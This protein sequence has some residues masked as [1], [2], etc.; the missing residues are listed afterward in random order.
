MRRLL[1]SGSVLALAVLVTVSDGAERRLFRP[2]GSLQG[3]PTPLESSDIPLP[4]PLSTAPGFSTAPEFQYSGPVTEMPVMPATVELYHNVKY[5]SVR[6]IAPCSKTIVV[7]V[8]DPCAK[9]RCDCPTPCV[10]VQICVPDCDCPHVRVSRH[11]N[12]VK[13]DYGKYEVTLVSARG[14]VIVDYDD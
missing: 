3:T 8:P 4:P 10:N 1:I 14:K 9:D 13:Y 12:R 5:R 2:I 11:G 6:N 7:Q